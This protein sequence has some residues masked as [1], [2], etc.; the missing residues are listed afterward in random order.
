MLLLSN[1]EGVGLS[2]TATTLR[3][4]LRA[5]SIGD[6]LLATIREYDVHQRITMAL[7]LLV[8]DAGD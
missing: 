2:F 3:S 8:A 6:D 5:N 1:P 7:Q 4:C